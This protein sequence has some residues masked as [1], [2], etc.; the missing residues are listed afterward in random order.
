VTPL[1]LALALQAS[2]LASP[3]GAP[4]PCQRPAHAGEAGIVFIGDT[5]FGQ[6]GA[7][8]WGPLSQAHVAAQLGKLCPRPDLVLFLG[9]NVYWRGSPD[10][11]GPRFDYM[12]APLFDAEG[13][14]VHAALGNHDV[15]GCQLSTQAAFATG[16][17]CADA[18]VRL[19]LEDAE[20]ESAATSP[21][22]VQELVEQARKTAG[23]DC[24]S[25]SE[26]AYEQAT[27]TSTAC[28]AQEALRHRAFGY[29]FRE[30]SPL[31]YYSLDRPFDREASGTRVRVLV[32]DSNTLR[33]GPGPEPGSASEQVL[34]P[35][36][37]R[38][39]LP[40]WDRLQALWLENQ[41]ATAP[42]DA[43][44]V[45]VGHHPGLSPVG[46][47]FRV[48][49]KCVGGHG[50]DEAVQRATFPIF[51]RQRPDVVLGAH[52]HFYARSRALDP[53]GHAAR[54]ATPGVRHFVSGGGGGPL[55]QVQPL[56]SRY[57]SAGSFHHFLYMRL[58]GDEAFFWAIDEHGRARDS[59]C[60]KRGDNVDRCITS[61]G[62]YEAADLACGVEPAPAAG[63]APPR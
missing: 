34:E 49:G 10:L 48:L 7:S 20:R 1:L 5:G 42:S 45:V 41:L 38:A 23:Q 2:S 4:D 8:E 39:P 24:P 61:P 25:S 60:F 57:A 40:R 22:L 14:R 17:T 55:Y 30:G 35:A 44:R 47:A 6:G 29:L 18:L 9:D 53:S 50:D 51:E 37:G 15:K 59:G 19:V 56:H 52:N 58:R 32:T 13:R 28:Y 33:R 11:F 63:C 43:W 21:L 16:E 31:R 27:G 46:C 3:C 54:G 26:L 12:Y 36:E 62:G